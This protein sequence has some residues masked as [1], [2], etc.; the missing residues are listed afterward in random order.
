[1]HRST[2]AALLVL[3]LTLSAPASSVAQR[4]PAAAPALSPAA[5]VGDRIISEAELDGLAR[6]R[7]SRVRNE[8]YAVRRQV[9]DDA[10]ARV[11]LERAAAARGLGLADFTRI[12]IDAQVPPVSEE[13]ARAVYD[14][15]PSRYGGQPFAQVAAQIRAGLVQSR[16]AETRRRLI[17]DLRRQSN[18]RVLLDAP[19]VALDAHE[20]PARG[21]ADAP[22]TIVEFSDF[23]CPYCR[24]AVQTL[25][26][27][28]AQFPG[29]VRIVFR[30]FPLPNHAD[31][32]RAAE[33][34]A[35]ADE[36]GQ[37]W[38]MHDA[39]FAA[40]SALRPA[41]LERRADELTL[42]G[43]RFREC[44]ASGRHTSRWQQGRALGQL[45]GVSAT[46]TFFINGRIVTGAVPYQVFHD[47]V[48]E[49][50]ERVGRAAASTGVVQS[51]DAGQ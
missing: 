41:D 28:E 45:H 20:G 15:G 17:A 34:A 2:P 1:M 42:D 10:I 47:L 36:Q 40:Q 7:L 26:R 18:V 48:T 21:P 13:Q 3:G 8:E 33:A 29:Q 23:Q 9:L 11:L 25:K 14:S 51:R 16:A 4:G 12:E 24:E 22:V 31:A 50:L 44:V 6:E 35:C 30:D 27:I 37:F 39:L 49:E 43:K 38:E 46:P 5:I 19:R 32:P